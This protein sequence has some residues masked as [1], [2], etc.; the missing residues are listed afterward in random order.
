[1]VASTAHLASAERLS[2]VVRAT[3]FGPV[4]SM[5]ELISIDAM[6]FF[7]DFRFLGLY[8]LDN[9]HQYIFRIKINMYRMTF[10]TRLWSFNDATVVQRFFLLESARLLLYNYNKKNNVQLK[11][12]GTSLKMRQT[13]FAPLLSSLDD[14][15]AYTILFLGRLR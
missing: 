13:T 15:S 2:S 6:F 14:D 8:N 9:N 10:L 7:V 4:K 1:M 12:F 5:H 11:T 3:D